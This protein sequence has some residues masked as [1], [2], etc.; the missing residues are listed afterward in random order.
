MNNMNPYAAQMFIDGSCYNN[1]GG[2]GG[3]A[4]ILEMP[5]YENEPKIIFQEGYRNTT[6]NRMEMMA[7][8][9]AIEY[10]KNNA[11]KLKENGINEVEI[12]SDSKNAIRCYNCA[13]LW[14]TNKWIGAH[15]NPIKNLDLLKKIITLKGSVHFSYEIGHIAN[16][17]NEA[18]KKVDKL[19]KEA[20]KKSILKN[21]SGY[22][23]PKVSKSKVR[24]ATEAYDANGQEIIIRIFEHAPVSRR[25]DSLY[26]IKFEILA[27]EGNE[28]Y[29]TYTSSEINSQLDRWHYYDAQFNNEPKNPRIES[30]NEVNEE[31]FLAQCD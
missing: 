10:I 1:P 8:I 3:L 28:K 27:K 7:V 12:W 26:K 20:T 13:E 24:G 11:T 29:Y 22:I 18:T 6:N 9:S 4:G 14:R 30:V 23:K 5:D 2:I 19:A 16:K 15:N 21:D 31:E 25:K 17:S